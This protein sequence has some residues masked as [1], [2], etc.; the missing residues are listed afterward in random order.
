M[1][2]CVVVCGGGVVL[3]GE[4]V[5]VLSLFMLHACSLARVP[6]MVRG[7]RAALSLGSSR[8]RSRVG[9]ELRAKQ[10]FACPSFVCAHV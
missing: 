1:S 5:F 7:A 10:V 6:T 9:S 8:W 4:R 2:E 3:C